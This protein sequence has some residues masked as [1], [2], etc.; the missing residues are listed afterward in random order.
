M[1][2]TKVFTPESGY[3]I[4]IRDGRPTLSS[5]QVK[6]KR[7]IY[8]P[9]GKQSGWKKKPSKQMKRTEKRDKRHE[10]Y[11]RELGFGPKIKPAG[12]LDRPPGAWHGYPWRNARAIG[13]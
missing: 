11:L 6:N 7:K 5:E 13:F 8:L 12:A 2:N 4:A 3:K 9:E 1:R 10:E